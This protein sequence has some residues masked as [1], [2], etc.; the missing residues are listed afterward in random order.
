MASKSWIIESLWKEDVYLK[1]DQ[2]IVVSLSQNKLTSL[3]V[4]IQIEFNLFLNEKTVDLIKKL[5]FSNRLK[6]IRP[7]I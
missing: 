6:D 5:T 1:I 3:L 4:I 7:S 2:N